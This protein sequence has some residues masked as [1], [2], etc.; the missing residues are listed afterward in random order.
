KLYQKGVRIFWI[1]NTGPI[2]CLPFLVVTYPPKP[3]DADQNGCIK[4]YNEVAQE[5]NKQLKKE[6]SKLR[7]QLSGAALFHVDI[8]SAKYSLI[9]EASKYGFINPLGY[10][11]PHLGDSGLKC[12][13]TEIVNGTEVFG[14]SCT[15]PSKYISWD[16]AH[17]TEAANK[18]IANRILDGSLTDPPVPLAKACRS[19]GSTRG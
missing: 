6:I 2:G 4:S 5:F 19:L 3:E 15:D 7:N 18:W 10:C 1:H 13:E 8:Y 16:S 12:W 14:T 17:Y 9:S 11:C